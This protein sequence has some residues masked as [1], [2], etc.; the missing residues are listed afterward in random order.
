MIC[1]CTIALFAYTTPEFFQ[2]YAAVNQVKYSSRQNGKMDLQIFRFA[3]V[4]TQSFIKSAS[5]SAPSYTHKGLVD[6]YKTILYGFMIKV[7]VK[8]TPARHH[9]HMH[10]PCTT[11]L[12]CKYTSIQHQAFIESGVLNSANSALRSEE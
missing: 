9:P 5:K 6:Q 10:A 8:I 7:A 4:K 12:I 11:I 1:A 3:H 2:F